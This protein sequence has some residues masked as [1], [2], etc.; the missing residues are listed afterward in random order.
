MGTFS[1][2]KFHQC[3]HWRSATSHNR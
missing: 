2:Q 3:R 1:N